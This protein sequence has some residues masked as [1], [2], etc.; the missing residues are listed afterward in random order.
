M[1]LFETLKADS[2]AARKARNE[3][4]SSLL[5]TL[6][7][8]AGAPG[9][10]D[11]NRMSTDAEVL[12]VIQKFLNGVDEMLAVRPDDARYQRE[13]VILAA[14]LPTRLE[15]VKLDEAI[16][17]AI[18]ESGLESPTAKDLGAIMKKLAELFPG[19][20]DGKNASAKIR[21]SLSS[22]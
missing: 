7:G 20:Y 22:M 12:K 9:K 6:L 10:N 5:I 17:R 15:G 18:R 19:A 3:V 4:D 1:S 13:R 21:T 8:E 11:G 14:Y 2:L 16:A